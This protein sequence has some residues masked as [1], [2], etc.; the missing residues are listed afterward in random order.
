MARDFNDYDDL[1]KNFD[2]YTS[3]NTSRDIS[4][5]SSSFKERDS[6]PDIARKEFAQGDFKPTPIRSNSSGNDMYFNRNQEPPTPKRKQNPNSP[7][8]RDPEKDLPT[9]KSSD[10]GNA[11][12]KSAKGMLPKSKADAYLDEIEKEESRK[13]GRYERDSKKYKGEVY[14]SNPPQE[15]KEEAERQKRENSPYGKYARKNKRDNITAPPLS[16][17]QEREVAKKK[18]EKTRK[19]EGRLTMKEKL[20]RLA[21]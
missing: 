11:A 5:S 6:K 15:I 13:R 1:L 19:A 21:I 7:F 12:F 3:K 8:Y 4:S 10:R 16:R 14:F 2:D 18:S 17:A 9:P 20:I